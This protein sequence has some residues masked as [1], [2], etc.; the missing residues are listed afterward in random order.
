M[1]QVQ[2]VT[3]KDG[4]RRLLQV[5]LLQVRILQD[6]LH[7]NTN[8]IQIQ[9][10]HFFL[11]VFVY[12]ALVNNLA[13]YSSSIMI[14]VLTFK[15]LI[16]FMNSIVFFQMVNLL[17]KAKERDIPKKVF[18]LFKLVGLLHFPFSSP[19][20]FHANVL[21]YLRLLFHWNDS[22][23]GPSNWIFCTSYS[24]CQMKL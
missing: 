21:T 5:I 10:I 8:K 18:F 15:S 14:H 3:S 6:G 17:H 1:L 23:I 16:F 13:Y 9:K 12:G 20:P 11:F 19:F 7:T 24:E 22:S 2:N 4:T